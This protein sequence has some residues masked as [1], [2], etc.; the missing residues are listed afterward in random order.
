MALTIH[1]T[2]LTRETVDVVLDFPT[3]AKL[4]KQTLETRPNK[5]NQQDPQSRGRE[6]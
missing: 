3:E 4:R 1:R 2:H 5:L 6:A